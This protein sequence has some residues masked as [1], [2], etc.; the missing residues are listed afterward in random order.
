MLGVTIEP[1][2]C[3]RS[4]RIRRSSCASFAYIFINYRYSD[5]ADSGWRCQT[6]S[7]SGWRVVRGSYQWS[8][9]NR[10]RHLRRVIKR[11]W[12]TVNYTDVVTCQYSSIWWATVLLSGNN[13]QISRIL[14][15]FDAGNTV[16][17]RTH[18]INF[19]DNDLDK[20]APKRMLPWRTR[21]NEIEG[22]ERGSEL[23]FHRQ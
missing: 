20:K 1:L 9:R 7:S 17:L 21:R 11:T 22:L 8:S 4:L 19:D 15:A 3:S 13:S 2:V 6:C 12:N 23:N 10:S 18:N 16:Q 14:N 5:Y